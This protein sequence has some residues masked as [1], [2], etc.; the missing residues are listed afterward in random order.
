[1]K[2]FGLGRE[3]FRKTFGSSL[4][5]SSVVK[6]EA[7]EKMRPLN[8]WMP[9]PIKSKKHRGRQHVEV[10]DVISVIQPTISTF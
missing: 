8:D 7:N 9:L 3:H 6:V 1:M 10:R 5:Y 4:P 2:W